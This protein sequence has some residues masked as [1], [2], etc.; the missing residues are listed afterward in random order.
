MENLANASSR[1]GRMAPSTTSKKVLSLR[2]SR[3][4]ENEYFRLSGR[5]LS[6]AHV[7]PLFLSGAS[8][9]FCIFLIIIFNLIQFFFHFSIPYIYR[10]RER[11]VSCFCHK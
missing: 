9:S 2:W 11:S 10:E 8:G 1:D 3:L 6:F 7:S 4:K 5:F